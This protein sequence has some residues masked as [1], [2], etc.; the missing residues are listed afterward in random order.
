MLTAAFDCSQD[1]SEQFFVMAGFVSSAEEWSDFDR[2]WRKRLKDD[3]LEYFHMQR[4]AHATTH[5]TKPFDKSWIGQERRRQRLISDLL[6]IIQSHGWRKFGCILPRQSFLMI[7]DGTRDNFIPKQIVLCARLLWAELEVWRKES[8]F[9]RPSEL[10][11]EQGDPGKGALIKAM[12]DITGQTPIFRYKRDNPAKDIAA[13]TP[14]HAS[15]ILAFEIQK[16]TTAEG[17]PIDEVVFRFPYAELEKMPGDIRLLRPHGAGLIDE[18]FRVQ[19]F[20]DD[21]PLPKPTV[22]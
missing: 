1:K 9:Q 19:K 21:N 2:E 10:V 17:K 4:F 15:D 8:K 14:L 12:E 13:F 20:F 11:F 7:S 22:R 18:W 5:P 16:L 3:N 6:G